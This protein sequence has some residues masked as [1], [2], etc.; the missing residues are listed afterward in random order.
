MTASP[1]MSREELLH[2]KLNALRQEHRDLDD[3]V[4]ALE[5]Q[6]LADRL[7]LQRMKKKKLALKDEIVRVEDEITPDII[8]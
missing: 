4:R 6:G 2:A 7:S 3:A 5:A 8:A 1:T